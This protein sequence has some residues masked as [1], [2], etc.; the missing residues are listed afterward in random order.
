MSTPRQN[1]VSLLRQTLDEANG[2]AIGSGCRT[3]RRRRWQVDRTSAAGLRP[4][5]A[6]PIAA[7][8][9][10]SIRHR[11][12]SSDREVV[13]HDLARC[14]SAHRNGWPTIVDMDRISAA[15]KRLAAAL[16]ARPEVLTAYVFGSAVTGADAPHDIDVAVVGRAAGCLGDLLR[17]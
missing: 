7:S 13:G 2:P 10:R 1:D 6:P 17:L 9:W 16:A 3:E 14:S 12:N 4:R 11:G 5:P 15:F 8:G